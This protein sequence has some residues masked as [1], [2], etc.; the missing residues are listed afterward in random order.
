MMAVRT[1]RLAVVR[2]VVAFA[3]L[4]VASSAV[5]R[6]TVPLSIELDGC[7][8]P[9]PACEKVRDVVELNVGDQKLSFAVEEMRLRNGASTS[10]LLTEMKLR[11]TR[12]H[13]PDE[14]LHKLVPGAHLHMRG[15]L[16]VGDRYL[17]V[18]AV[19]PLG[20]KPR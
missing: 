13:G 6:R 7:V 5:A 19:E 14:F 4:V 11:P 17:M 12:V 8:L 3:A 10:R 18:M 9:A 1:T 16:R 20:E 2:A 15:G